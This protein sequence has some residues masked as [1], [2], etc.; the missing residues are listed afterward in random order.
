MDSSDP[1]SSICAARSDS[2]PDA[3]PADNCLWRIDGI[4]GDSFRLTPEVGEFSL[5][6]GG[7]WTGAEA[8]HRTELYLAEGSLNVLDCSGTTLQFGG[9]AGEPSC[10]V[11]QL[12][13]AACTPMAVIL[14][15]DPSTNSCQIDKA[16]SSTGNQLVGE[17]DVVFPDEAW[18]SL[19]AAPTRTTK[20]YFPGAS[21]PFEPD[22]CIDGLS[23]SDPSGVDAGNDQVAGDG[24]LEWA[25]ILSHQ[26][27]YKGQNSSLQD[28]MQVTQKILFWGDIAFSR[29]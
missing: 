3:G 5:E 23:A 9:R 17:L 16:T 15:A 12:Q 2:G 26:V 8:D 29:N 6:G 25:C 20:V 21:D 13:T 28:L 1:N 10:S 19:L 24:V 18:E 27:D 11:H 4:L 7:D 22:L 14:S